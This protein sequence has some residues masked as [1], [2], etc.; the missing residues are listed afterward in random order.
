M[1]GEYIGGILAGVGIGIMVANALLPREHRVFTI[2][3][4]ALAF[5]FIAVGTSIAS[6]A[7]HRRKQREEQK[8]VA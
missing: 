6:T 1:S 4:F 8:H 7:H 2:G 3:V 5:V